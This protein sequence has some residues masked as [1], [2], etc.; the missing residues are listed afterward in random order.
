LQRAWCLNIW[1]RWHVKNRGSS[2]QGKYAI[3]FLAWHGSGELVDLLGEV[4]EGQSM[5]GTIVLLV[6]RRLLRCLEELLVEAVQTEVYCCYT[7][8]LYTIYGGYPRIS[9]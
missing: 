2:Y 8:V 5:Y 7:R 4:G 6:T 1:L 3:Y 9:P